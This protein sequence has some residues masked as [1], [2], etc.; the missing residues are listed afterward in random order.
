[1]LES[2]G[3]VLPS[4]LQSCNPSHVTGLTV[5]VKPAM[6]KVIIDVVLIKTRE[7]VPIRG[8]ECLIPWG[9]LEKSVRKNVRN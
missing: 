7:L 4:T 3:I 5:D 8:E 6:S 2:L 1:M 9:N